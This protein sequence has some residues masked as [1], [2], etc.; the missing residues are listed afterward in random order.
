MRAFIA[1]ARKIPDM[2]A[3]D[4]AF[5]G[6]RG[7]LTAQCGDIKHAAG[8]TDIVRGMLASWST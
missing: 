3:C 2:M 8:M 1:P 5:V 6:S 4:A 7:H